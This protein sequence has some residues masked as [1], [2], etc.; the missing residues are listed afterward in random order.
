MPE[1]EGLSHEKRVA[2]N[3]KIGLR[4]IWDIDCSPGTSIIKE[5]LQMIL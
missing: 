2:V 1:A 3:S 4:G 5:T